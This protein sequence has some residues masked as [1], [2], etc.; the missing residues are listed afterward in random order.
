MPLPSKILKGQI[1]DHNGSLSFTSTCCRGG[2]PLITVIH[3]PPVLSPQPE[4]NHM[5]MLHALLI[6]KYFLYVHKYLLIKYGTETLDGLPYLLPSILSA[7]SFEWRLFEGSNM[8]E[9]NSRHDLMPFPS[10]G[11]DLS[12]YP[13]LVKLFTGHP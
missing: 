2:L 6:R 1:E 7:L 12:K 8:L 11:V 3:Q 9:L 10:Q 4:A 5:F 13:Q